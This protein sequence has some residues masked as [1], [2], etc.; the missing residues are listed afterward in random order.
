MRAE[1]IVDIATHIGI[2]AEE[3]IEIAGKLSEAR[4]LEVTGITDSTD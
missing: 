4:L 3:A 2:S 1:V